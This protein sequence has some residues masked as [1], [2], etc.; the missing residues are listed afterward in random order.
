MMMMTFVNDPTQIMSYAN[1]L[2]KIQVRFGK[3]QTM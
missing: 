3:I 1:K 2:M